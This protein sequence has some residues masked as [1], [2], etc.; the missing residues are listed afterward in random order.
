MLP[1]TITPILI[2]SITMAWP[3]LELESMAKEL[4]RL[5]TLLNTKNLHI[6]LKRLAITEQKTLTAQVWP[7]IRMEKSKISKVCQ[8]HFLKR[9]VEKKTEKT[10]VLIKRKQTRPSKNLLSRQ[11]LSARWNLNSIRL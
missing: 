5:T 1:E 7:F 9:Q 8:S 6:T 4:C 2:T 11:E 10:D 3:E